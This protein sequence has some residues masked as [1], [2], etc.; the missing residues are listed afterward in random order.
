MG[1]VLPLSNRESGTAA[2]WLTI[3][4]LELFHTRKQMH[5][6]QR[7]EAKCRLNF[8][9]T[10]NG[11]MLVQ[12]TSFIRW[13]CQKPITLDIRMYFWS[14]LRSS[15]SLWSHLI[16]HWKQ[17][18]KRGLTTHWSV[19]MSPGSIMILQTKLFDSFIH[20]NFCN[21]SPACNVFYLSY[22]EPPLY[23]IY[24]RIWFSALGVVG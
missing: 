9:S 8:H 14:H 22:Y 5:I 13:H 10:R 23:D 16:R 20:I 6:T 24:I 2:V 18:L 12:H 15:C 3:S 7:V 11:G 4:V 17:Y 1:V 19:N 21:G